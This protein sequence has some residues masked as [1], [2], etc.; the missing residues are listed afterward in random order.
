VTQGT[1]TVSQ[2]TLVLVAVNGQGVGT[3][4]LTA[5]GG[6]VSGYSISVPSG[7]T[8]S[9][10]SGSLASGAS[11]TITVHSTSLITLDKQLTISPGGATVTVVLNVSL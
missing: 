7:L 8:V 1:L 4:T 9:P 6:P 2:T 3:F 5:K 10:A 11:V